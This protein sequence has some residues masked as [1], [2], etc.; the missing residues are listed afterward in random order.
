MV[1][2]IG[3]KYN[4]EIIDLEKDASEIISYLKPSFTAGWKST[5]LCESL[6]HGIVPIE[7]SDAATGVLPTN[8]RIRPYGIGTGLWVEEIEIF[9]KK[10]RCF[11]WEE[12]KER[13]FDLL[14]DT[15]LYTKT[16]S[17]LRTR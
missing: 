7:L 15:S 11:S 2:K 3:E 14:E 1:D 13:I 6:R 8:S 9:P 4:L 16:L 17:E 12:E 10:R 5:T